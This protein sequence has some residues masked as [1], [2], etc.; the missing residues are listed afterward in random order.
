MEDVIYVSSGTVEDFNYKKV[1]I[2]KSWM[3]NK[4]R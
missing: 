4:N 2:E 3:D 1:I